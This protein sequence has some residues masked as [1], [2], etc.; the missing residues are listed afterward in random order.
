MKTQFKE[1][2]T[3]CYLTPPRLIPFITELKDLGGGMLF[4]PF[5]DPKSIIP[6]SHGL[7]VRNGQDAYAEDWAKFGSSDSGKCALWVNGPYSRG[8]AERTTRKFAEA[9]Q[10]GAFNIGAMICISELGAKKSRPLFEAFG[11]L[12]K[13]KM[14]M[15]MRVYFV[16]RLGFV[17]GRDIER[18]NKPTIKAGT[19]DDSPRNEVMIVLVSKVNMAP[20][21]GLD[22]ALTGNGFHLSYFDT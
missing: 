10:S 1:I 18:E 20:R 8:H 2:V 13:D 4:D 11:P 22:R 5:S 17:A 15:R 21:D 14:G 6:S 7:D 9:M 19:L 3:D 16:G 12:A